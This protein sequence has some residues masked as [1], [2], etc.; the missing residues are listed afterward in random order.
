MF[1]Q[2]WCLMF[3]EEWFMIRRVNRGG[4]WSDDV[5]GV[6]YDQMVW[7]G[8]YMI[9]FI[10]LLCYYMNRF[11]DRNDVWW[12]CFDGGCVLAY[13]LIGGVQSDVLVEMMYGQIDWRWCVIRCFDRGGV[14]SDVLTGVLYDKIDKIF[15]RV[16]LDQMTRQEWCMIRQ[17]DR[18]SILSDDLAG[19]V[20]DQTVW[21]GWCVIRWFNRGGAWSDSLTGV[22]CDQMI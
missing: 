5:I 10:F 18:G 8:Y 11:I 14:S 22:M 19:A 2:E 3:R 15:D 9:I 16:V 21:Q 1:W 6:A 20:Y 7:Q 13:V 17:C 12:G 4:T